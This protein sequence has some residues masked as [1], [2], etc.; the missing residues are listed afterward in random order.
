MKTVFARAL[1]IL[2]VVALPAS[3]FAS[4]KTTHSHAMAKKDPKKHAGKHHEHKT[5]SSKTTHGAVAAKAQ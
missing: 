3:A 2:A 5:A 1:V 4:S